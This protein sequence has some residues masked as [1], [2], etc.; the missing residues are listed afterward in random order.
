MFRTEPDDELE[1]LLGEERDSIPD[2]GFTVKVLAALPGRRKRERTRALVLLA[3]TLIGGVLGLFVLP[4]G[5][6]LISVLED[7]SGV[8]SLSLSSW[9]WL[10]LLFMLGSIT[11]LTYAFEALLTTSEELAPPRTGI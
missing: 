11:I 10:L 1:M 3:T 7:F 6:L 8:P 2:A 9:S 5:E 4:G